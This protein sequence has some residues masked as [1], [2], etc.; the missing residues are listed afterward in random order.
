MRT[1]DAVQK[2]EFINSAIQRGMALFNEGRF[3][4]AEVMFE[5]VARAPDT[6]PFVQHMRGLIADRL[7][8]REDAKILLREA[9]ELHPE[10]ASAH[11]NLGRLLLEDG[12]TA[13][14]VAAFAAAVR[15]K[16]DNPVNHFSLA[17]ALE[18]ARQPDLAVGCHL[19]ALS[20][21]PDYVEAET[22]LSQCLTF[23]G[24]DEEAIGRLNQALERHPDSAALH[25]ARAVH[26]LTAGDWPAGWAEYDWRWHDPAWEV[27]PLLAPRPRWRGENLAGKILLLQAGL[28]FG[29]TLQ[30]LRYAPLLKERG[31]KLILR[32][33]PALLPLVAGLAPFDAA[34]SAELPPPPFD[35][36]APLM[37]LPG[38]LGATPETVPPAFVPAADPEREA[39][40]RRRLDERFGEGGMRIGLCWQGAPA[41]HHDRQR[42]MPL[43]MLSPLFAHPGLR[44]VGLQ[45]EN[46]TDQVAAHGA[47]LFDA[48]AE[49]DESSFADAAA[50]IR[51]LDLVIS[52]DSA[53]AHLAAGLGRPTWI[54]L[55]ASAD[56]RWSRRRADTPW[57][58][59]A[60][61]F[62]QPE[63][64][65]WHDVTIEVAQ[66]LAELAPGWEHPPSPA[67]ASPRGLAETIL[68]DALFTE[69]CRHHETGAG[70]RAHAFYE[71]ALTTDPDH[72]ETL[73][74]FAALLTSEGAFDRARGL[75]ERAVRLEPQRAVFRRVLADTLRQA[76]LTPQ[77][78]GHYRRALEQ[79]PQDATVHAG[80][81]LA[82][83]T[84][85]DLDTALKHFQRATEIDAGQSSDFFVALGETLSGLD[86]TEGAERAFRHAISLES[87]SVAAHCALGS[88]LLKSER[89]TEAEVSFETAAAAQPDCAAAHVGWGDAALAQGNVSEAWIHWR[90]ARQID[91]AAAPGRSE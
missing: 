64:G 1:Q 67:A 32:V 22:T 65:R 16:P 76:G 91:P 43:D 75:A 53:I 83:Q 69:A 56:W 21:A 71:A 85:G 79:A 78:I 90:A 20:I 57:Y 73:C 74:N 10:V 11:A 39:H 55:P 80:L 23:L 12:Q 38:L 86:R 9:I 33:P 45:V 63:A 72:R 62:R 30:F 46:G 49:F 6:R 58:P 8:R 52:V 2:P 42:S 37:S 18:A 82:L 89:P 77:A 61:L 41:N 51:G 29:D 24:R 66:A 68:A 44:F 50:V 3:D 14:A 26:L 35:F 25:V 31:A 28:G 48:G 5:M 84:S 19:D 15:L 13:Q 59:S 36:Y 40:W 60:R 27:G 17:C 81:A 88:L 34:I 87:T 54:L 4:S 70:A 7:G 47:R